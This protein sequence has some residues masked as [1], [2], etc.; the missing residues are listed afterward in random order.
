[1][2]AS[3][4]ESVP[5]LFINANRAASLTFVPKSALKRNVSALSC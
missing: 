2:V 1:M 4:P 5:I 3:I